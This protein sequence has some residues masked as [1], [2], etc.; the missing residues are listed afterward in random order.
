M[1]RGWGELETA[2][3]KAF[4]LPVACELRFGVE[5]IKH[6]AADST[7]EYRLN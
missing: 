4:G 7:A 5:V 3:R 6:G 2:V 1:V